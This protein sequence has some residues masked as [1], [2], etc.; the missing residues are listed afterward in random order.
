[1]TKDQ[2][3]IYKIVFKD[4]YNHFYNLRIILL[5]LDNFKNEIICIS[6]EI[7][8]ATTSEMIAIRKSF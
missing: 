2:N 3:H 7:S 5:A 4:N 1:M 8:V 6:H